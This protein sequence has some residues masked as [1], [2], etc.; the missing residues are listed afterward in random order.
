[1]F[2]R[3]SFASGQIEKHCLTSPPHGCLVVCGSDI[4][5]RLCANSTATTAIAR[6]TER[7]IA[8]KLLGKYAPFDAVRL[9]EA[10]LAVYPAAL[11]IYRVWELLF[12]E[13]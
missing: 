3:R 9:S 5:V 12:L 4:V 6:L 7:V 11:G 8:A 1:M 2:L 10:A 13:Q